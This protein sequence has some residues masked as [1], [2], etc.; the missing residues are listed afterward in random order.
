MH[1]QPGNAKVNIFLAG[2]ALSIIRYY[3]LICIAVCVS[4]ISIIWQMTEW[5]RPSAR[6][7]AM[8]L[9]FLFVGL[10][11]WAFWHDKQ[12]LRANAV[13]YVLSGPVVTLLCIIL[14]YHAI[15][16]VQHTAIWS[17][18]DHFRV[19]IAAVA[20]ACSVALLP[21]LWA[22]EITKLRYIGKS[23]MAMLRSLPRFAEAPAF[24]PEI[25][26]RQES[27]KTA[28]L[29][30]AGATFLAISTLLVILFGIDT[31]IKVYQIPCWIGLFLLFKSRMYGS[32]G[33]LD[34]LSGDRRMP[35]LFLRSFG[36]ESRI[37][38]YLIN[39][40]DFSLETRLTHFA[41]SIGPF[42]AIGQPGEEAPRPGA[43]KAYFDNTAWR[44]VIEN[45]IQKS[46]FL[47]MQFDDTPSLEWEL[48][49]ILKA[50][51]HLKL[52]LLIRQTLRHSPA[53]T[54]GRLL[55]AV[56]D[57]PWHAAV[58]SISG[59]RG[60]IAIVLL[61]DGQIVEIRSLI[62]TR[63]V[64]EMAVYTCAALL[65]NR[66]TELKTVNAGNS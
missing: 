38:I 18:A 19:I 43:A 54:V 46:R 27:K 16:E 15:D 22:L 1:S 37:K 26:R 50:R 44:S 8:M 48:G 5:S 25:T 66:H 56:R 39:V 65:T 57:T 2:I 45:W 21:A 11:I 47:I 32:V 59:Q 23:P 29:E 3:A 30:I 33:A 62:F 55:A 61:D 49:T 35:V 31:E 10:S 7:R 51:H 41:N 4:E 40:F 14:L 64:Y 17:P 52:I 60:L 9:I 6:S 24:K 63:S 36:S 13:A 34:T 42:I 12:Q 20:T 58:S 28:R 53:P